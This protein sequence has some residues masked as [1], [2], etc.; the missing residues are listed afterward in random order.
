MPRRY[1][2]LE[3]ILQRQSMSSKIIKK[4]ATYQ[5]YSGVELEAGYKMALVDVLLEHQLIPEK[6]I[7]PVKLYRAYLDKQRKAYF[8]STCSEISKLGFLLGSQRRESSADGTREW[9]DKAR[10]ASVQ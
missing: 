10:E 3:S 1:D 5:L 7:V 2:T 8:A 6:F 9:L 4:D